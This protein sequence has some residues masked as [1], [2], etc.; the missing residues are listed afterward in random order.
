MVRPHDTCQGTAVNIEQLISSKIRLP[1]PPATAVR[2]LQAVQEDDGSMNDLARIIA[3]D[4]VLTAKLL[5]LANSSIYSLSCRVATI[6]KALTVLGVNL[7][8]NIALSFVCL[9]E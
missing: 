7:I 3:T 4:P 2:I 1:S 8:K 6:D 5:R 9:Q